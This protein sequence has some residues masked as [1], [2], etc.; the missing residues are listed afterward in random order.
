M[1]LRVLSAVTTSIIG[2]VSHNPRQGPTENHLAHTEGNMPRDGLGIGGFAPSNTGRSSGTGGNADVDDLFDTTRPQ[3]PSG[4]LRPVQVS[5][6]FK[7]Q[8]IGR[9]QDLNR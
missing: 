6:E 5:P 3:R 1:L 9:Y 2:S 7:M 4:P 8:L